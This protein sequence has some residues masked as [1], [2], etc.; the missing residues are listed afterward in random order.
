MRDSLALSGIPLQGFRLLSLRVLMIRFSKSKGIPHLTDVLKIV[1]P[2]YFLLF[3]LLLCFLPFRAASAAYGSSQA[4][5]PIRVTAANLHHS[6]QQHWILVPLSE[7]RNGTHNLMVTSS[8]SF[9]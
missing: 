9:C 3:F 4:R 7:A 5:G 1:E 6:S 2:T 8:I